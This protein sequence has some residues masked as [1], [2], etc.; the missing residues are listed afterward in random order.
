MVM[1]AIHSTVQ[2]HRQTASAIASSSDFSANDDVTSESEPDS[3][4]VQENRKS[5]KMRKRKGLSGVIE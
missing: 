4:G 1:I 5:Q 3:D 2:K